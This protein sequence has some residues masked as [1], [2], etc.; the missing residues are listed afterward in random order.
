MRKSFCAESVCRKLFEVFLESNLILLSE[1]M[2]FYILIL[3]GIIIAQRNALK[4]LQEMCTSR[5]FPSSNWSW[6]LVY[7]FIRVQ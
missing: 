4:I 3:L 6:R 2:N 7:V 5:Q 1:I